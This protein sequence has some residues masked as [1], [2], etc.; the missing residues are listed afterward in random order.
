M[1]VRLAVALAM[2]CALIA[3]APPGVLL[4]PAQHSV[5]WPPDARA[6]SDWVL[7]LNWVVAIL[8]SVPFVIATMLVL[9][10]R[11]TRER[12]QQLD[13]VAYEPML[14]G[15]V[16]EHVEED[17]ALW[18]RRQRTALAAWG[19]ERDRI[20]SLQDRLVLQALAFGTLTTFGLLCCVLVLS[21]ANAD[22]SDAAVVYAYSVIA[23]TATVFLSNVA[24]IL[25]RISGGDVT[26]RTFSWAIRSVILVIVAD[27]GLAIVLG[28][29]IDGARPAVLLGLFVGATG[30]HAIQFLLDKASKAF[31]VGVSRQQE[32]SPLLAIE[33]ITD[34]HVSRLEEEGLI[35]IHDLAFAPAARLFFATAYSLQQICNWQDRALLY[36]YVGKAGADALATSM[37]VRGAIDLRA[38]CHD[39]LYGANAE[40]RG[41]IRAS[42]MKA[43]S[44]DDGGILAFT[45]S[46][47]HDEAT[48]RIRYYWGASVESQHATGAKDAAADA[49]QGDPP[50]APQGSPPVAMN[51]A[52]DAAQ[53]EPPG[54]PQGSPTVA[55]NGAAAH[56]TASNGHKAGGGDGGIDAAK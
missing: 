11:A 55:M 53:G 17:R 31:S 4:Q 40:S 49:A 38:L 33:G 19:Y 27:L 52:A 13:L 35:S 46:M 47:A 36:V 15:I 34:E 48:M 41:Q 30:D 6:W 8:V 42:L 43:L 24:R 37:N 32:P 25:L 3:L 14:S 44:L 51:A 45:H 7:S 16:G 21:S 39:V 5:I 1:G 56:A 26:T 50:G 29:Q 28:S 18:R 23:A 2:L 20:G 10:L 22:S 9:D 12:A 54:A